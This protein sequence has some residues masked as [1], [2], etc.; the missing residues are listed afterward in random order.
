MEYASKNGTFKN[1]IDKTDVFIKNIDPEIQ[2]YI[3]NLAVKNEKTAE[4]I[5]KNMHKFNVNI[6]E[7]L[8]E[9]F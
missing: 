7:T 3:L 2:E 6:P 8:K 4:D 9:N 1:L 5:S